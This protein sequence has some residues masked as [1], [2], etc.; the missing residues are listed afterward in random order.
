MTT[1]ERIRAIRKEKG[2][3]QKQVADKCGMADSA[4]R[5]YESGTVQPRDVTLEKIASALDVPVYELIEIPTRLT[6]SSYKN[7][8]ESQKEWNC[9][10]NVTGLMLLMNENAQKDILSFAHL[11]ARIPQNRKEAIKL[12]NVERLLD[13]LCRASVETCNSTDK[14]VGLLLD[15][16]NLNLASAIERAGSP[17]DKLLL[18]IEQQPESERDTLIMRLADMWNITNIPSS[19]DVKDLPR[20]IKTEYSLLHKEEKKIIDKALAQFL[21]EISR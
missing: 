18:Y 10:E 16:Y 17:L 21:E 6:F 12:P 20:Y 7:L 5:K 14:A 19:L 3:T 13:F 11:L 2:M 4:I 8:L 9:I 15:A 1:G